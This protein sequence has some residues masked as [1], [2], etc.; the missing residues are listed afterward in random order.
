[1][2]YEKLRCARFM[3][4]LYKELRKQLPEKIVSEETYPVTIKGY[5]IHVLYRYS[6]KFFDATEDLQRCGY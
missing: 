4:M 5:H 3:Y 2:D 6:K 1:M